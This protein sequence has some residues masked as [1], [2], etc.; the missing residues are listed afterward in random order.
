[1]NNDGRAGLNN[2]MENEQVLW[3]CKEGRVCSMQTWLLLKPSESDCRLGIEGVNVG[4]ARGRRAR[5]C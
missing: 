1:M 4:S 5:R 3:Y 2:E